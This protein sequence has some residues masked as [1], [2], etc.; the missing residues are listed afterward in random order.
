MPVA[1]AATVS[2]L[3]RQ[4]AATWARWIGEGAVNEDFARL[5]YDRIAA[6]EPF[7]GAYGGNRA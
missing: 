2:R 3:D 1:A 4:L 7:V 6:G 5:S